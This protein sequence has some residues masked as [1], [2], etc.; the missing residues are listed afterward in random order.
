VAPAPYQG[1]TLQAAEK[2]HW[3]VVLKGRGFSRAAKVLYLCH[4]EW[5][6]S[7]RGICFSEFFCNLF[8]RAEKDKQDRAGFSPCGN[9]PSAAKA[10]F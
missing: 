10:G 9:R 7:P 6:F 1:K 3:G 8:S 2:L 5:G 4:S